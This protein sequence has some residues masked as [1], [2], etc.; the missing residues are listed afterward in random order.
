VYGSDGTEIYLLD[1]AGGATTVFDIDDLV[2]VA[3]PFGILEASWDD[4]NNVLKLGVSYTVGLGS[5][6][7]LC[8]ASLDLSFASADV[9]RADAGYSWT[10]LWE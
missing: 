9:V 4:L 6:A 10:L 8:Y 2:G 3:G 7:P 5:V 1:G